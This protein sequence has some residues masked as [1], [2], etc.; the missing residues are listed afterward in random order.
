MQTLVDTYPGIRLTEIADAHPTLSLD[1]VWALLAT[2]RLFTDLTA[3]S[4]MD[5][6][7]V[8]LYRHEAEANHAARP[9]VI[10]SQPQSPSPPLI[11]DGRLF[12]VESVGDVITLRP[13]IGEMLTLPSERFQRLMQTGAMRTMT[14]ADPSPTT[15]EI[16]EAFL[17]ASP[18]A[19][20]TANGRLEQILIYAQGGKLTT[21][22]RTVQRW[23]GAYTAVEERYG[24]GYIGL[25][26]HVA[27]R[28]NRT[29]R[30]SDASMQMLEQYL[31]EHYTTPQ[32]KRAAAVYRLYCEECARKSLPPVSQ[33]TFY[34]VRARFTTPDVTVAR[35]GRRAASLQWHF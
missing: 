4:L 28:G 25:L 10:I 13:E 5:H 23:M 21:P 33:R 29:P 34:R 30:I 32:A 18:R 22:E 31:K 8:R 2:R 12:L 26:D 9:P 20:K 16:R 19:Q 7:Q 24:C 3:T 15:P 14:A 35:L 6:G 27:D 11:W 17:R 1:V